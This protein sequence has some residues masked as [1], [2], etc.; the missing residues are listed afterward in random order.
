MDLTSSLTT[1]ET[2]STPASYYMAKDSPVLAADTTGISS[3]VEED[4]DDEMDDCP[5]KPRYRDAQQ[6]PHELK[7]HCQIHLEEQLC[8][9]T[10]QNTSCFR[11]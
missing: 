5:D 10:H 9:A 7:Q 11:V 8:N 6:L 2:I 1:F 3:S 4:I